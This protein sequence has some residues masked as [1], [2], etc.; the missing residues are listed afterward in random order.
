MRSKQGAG[1]K[2]GHKERDGTLIHALEKRLKER[3][4]KRKPL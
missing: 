2:K 3:E 4:R 1:K